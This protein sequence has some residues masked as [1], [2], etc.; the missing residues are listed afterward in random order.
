MKKRK[1]NFFA[2]IAIL[3]V[4]VYL[5]IVFSSTQATTEQVTSVVAPVPT[6]KMSKEY[7]AYIASDLQLHYMG[8]DDKYFGEVTSYSSDDGQT[9][10][11]LSEFIDPETDL[12]FTYKEYL[13]DMNFTKVSNGIARSTYKD[14]VYLSQFIIHDDSAILLVSS[15]SKDVKNQILSLFEINVSDYLPK[16]M[17]QGLNS[18]GEPVSFNEKPVFTAEYLPY[19]DL[20]VESLALLSEINYVLGSASSQSLT[21]KE[22]Q[23]K[24]PEVFFY[25]KENTELM[26][27]PGA[28]TYMLVYVYIPEL[29]G[30]IS[31]LMSGKNIVNESVSTNDCFIDGKVYLMS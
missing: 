3:L 28:E 2:L 31:I 6:D 10:I 11:V 9:N 8:T 4:A 22:L 25:Q 27:E 29:D 7:L 1:K 30:Y 23:E 19:L 12:E 26:V 15:S 13:R 14:G 20:S 17:A 5:I 21:F 24:H 18:D 16:D